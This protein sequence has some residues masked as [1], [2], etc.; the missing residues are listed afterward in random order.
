MSLAVGIAVLQSSCHFEAPVFTDNFA[1]A[2][3]SLNGVWL[4]QDEEGDPRSAQYAVCA[5]IDAERY[6][7][8]HPARGSDSFY[9]EAR[10]V[11]RRGRTL[12]QL[13]VLTTFKGG[14]PSVGSNLHTLL[15]IEQRE[16]DRLHVRALDGKAPWPA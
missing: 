14:V 7:L 13:R 16:G 6:L 15:W 4:A 3:G 12:L 9:Y 1:K 2:D 5:R 10:P 11:K 8:H